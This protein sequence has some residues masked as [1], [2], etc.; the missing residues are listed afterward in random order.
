ME[1][2]GID[3]PRIILLYAHEKAVNNKCYF[4]AQP[5]QKELT[6]DRMLV[7]KV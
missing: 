2:Q 4:S 7:K 6:A 3:T 5:R 1:C